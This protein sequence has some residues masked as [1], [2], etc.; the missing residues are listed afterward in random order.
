MAISSINRIT[1][2]S[3]KVAPF[4]EDDAA[5]QAIVRQGSLAGDEKIFRRESIGDMRFKAKGSLADFDKDGDGMIT[6]QE[7]EEYVAGHLSTEKDKALLKKAL[8][9]AI[10]LLILFAFA[11]S[12]MTFAVVEMTKES[13]VR[14]APKLTLIVWC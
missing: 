1:C 7:L 12:G 5:T 3:D 13:K 2:M 8:L 6:K 9:A 10:A 14:N 11:I 4:Q